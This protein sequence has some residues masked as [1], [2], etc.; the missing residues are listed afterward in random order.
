MPEARYLYPYKVS[1]YGFQLPGKDFCTLTPSVPLLNRRLAF[2]LIFINV[3]LK[4]SAIDIAL[5][6]FPTPVP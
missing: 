2:L 3:F 5:H 1:G 6:V 4:P